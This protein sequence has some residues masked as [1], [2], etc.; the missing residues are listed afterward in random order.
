MRMAIVWVVVVGMTAGVAGAAHEVRAGHAAVEDQA[1]HPRMPAAG[2]W[3]GR[4]VNGVLSLFAAALGVGLMVRASMAQEVPPPAHSHDEPPGAS[5]HHGHGGEVQPAPTG[6]SD[7][8][9]HGHSG[10]H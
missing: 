5:G 8:H 1:P 6:E 2:R 4:M 10:H 9:G 7:K 3:A